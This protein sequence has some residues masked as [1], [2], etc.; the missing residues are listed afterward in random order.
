MVC[1]GSLDLAIPLANLLAYCRAGA[2]NVELPAT[3]YDKLNPYWQSVLFIDRNTPI[4]AAA[5][6]IITDPNINI[7]GGNVFYGPNI[8]I[9]IYGLPS[10]TE[11]AERKL[12]RKLF[13]THFAPLYIDGETLTI[14]GINIFLG[15]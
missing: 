7:R 5:T 8:A 2:E 13:S 4:Q 15:A 12:W 1:W 10:P 11:A 3:A 6:D 9:A 14:D